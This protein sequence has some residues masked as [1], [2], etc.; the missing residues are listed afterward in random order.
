[1]KT[2]FGTPSPAERLH[3][4]AY[5]CR[6]IADTAQQEATRQ[7]LIQMAER[8]ERLARVR[9]NAHSSQDF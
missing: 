5:E 9:E 7:E 8:L 1:M 2:L 4:L 3:R 6:E